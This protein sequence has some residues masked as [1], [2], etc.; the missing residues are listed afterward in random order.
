MVEDKE[1]LEKNDL[2]VKEVQVV[3]ACQLDLVLTMCEISSISFLF[4]TKRRDLPSSPSQFHSSL[5]QGKTLSLSLSLSLSLLFLLCV[6]ISSPFQFSVSLFI[7]FYFLFALHFFL[8]LFQIPLIFSVALDFILDSFRNFSYL[9]FD[10]RSGYVLARSASRVMRSHDLNHEL[11]F[12]VSFISVS[13]WNR[14]FLN[15]GCSCM[16]YHL[17]PIH[18]T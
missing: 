9:N 11:V 16:Q 18:F 17:L 14:S 4:V 3:K 2:E 8:F 6:W 13:D 15:C 10:L 5:L 12:F 7:F 1:E